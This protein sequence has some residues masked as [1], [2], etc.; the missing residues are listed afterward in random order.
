MGQR[1]M[2]CESKRKLNSSAFV[3]AMMQSLLSKDSS[4]FISNTSEITMVQIQE[5]VSPSLDTRP[6]KLSAKRG[7]IPSPDPSVMYPPG[8]CSPKHRDIN[9]GHVNCKK[10]PNRARTHRLSTKESRRKSIANQ[11]SNGMAPEHTQDRV[12]AQELADPDAFWR[13]QAQNIHWHK[14][15][16]EACQRSSKTLKSGVTHDQWTWFPG[17]EI[18]TT[19]NCV[20]RHVKNG[21]GNNVAIYWDSPVTRAK[22]QFTYQQLLDEV[23]TLA[24]VLRE[25]GVKKGDVVLIYMPM[26]PAALF[27]MLAI[28]R[29]GAI[30]AVVFGGFAPTALAQRIEASRP[31]AI[32]TASCG[33]EGTKG[34]SGYKRMIEEAVERSTFKPYKIVIWQ[35][36]E[37]RWDPVVKENGQRN[38]QRLV[39]SAKNRGVKADAVPVKSDD[40]LYVIYTSGEVPFHWRRHILIHSY[41]AVRNLR[42]Q[43]ACC[44]E[45]H[46]CYCPYI[47]WYTADMEKVLLV[48]RK[49]W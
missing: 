29:L 26:I 33:I 44:Y 23:E 22:E 43:D 37:L 20:D 46:I 16:N 14:E 7:N 21:N 32:M 13:T 34:P 19:Y 12:Y 17:G 3:V 25:E 4:P 24:G 28:A 42:N 35:R 47:D 15:P 2:R 9:P 1:Q 6:G 39:K 10:H 8:R 30:H 40:G 27:A 5:R 49:V 18:S 31:K 36:D 11:D 38:W 48:Y 41:A 45:D